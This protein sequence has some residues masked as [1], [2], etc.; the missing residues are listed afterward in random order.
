M[1]RLATA[2]VSQSF[3]YCSTTP[4]DD[5]SS[6]IADDNGPVGE[7]L[8][9]G[10]KERRDSVTPRIAMER[11]AHMNSLEEVEVDPDVLKRVLSLGLGERRRRRG[12]YATFAPTSHAAGSTTNKTT[13][14]GAGCQRMNSCR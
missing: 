3:R 9:R 14:T 1:G 4:K 2:I 13:L 7:R 12:V 8:Q 10:R 11:V 6:E 5:Y